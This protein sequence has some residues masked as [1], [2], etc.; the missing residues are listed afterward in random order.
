MFKCSFLFFFLQ[1]ESQ[2]SIQPSISTKVAPIKELFPHIPSFV[3]KT[4]ESTKRPASPY[5]TTESTKQPASPYCSTEYS[6]DDLT[7][8][9]HCPEP[10]TT[11]YNLLTLSHKTRLTENECDTIFSVPQV[12][13]EDHHMCQGSTERLV[14][15]EFSPSQS[16]A[17]H[18]IKPNLP[19][20]P[21]AD[22]GIKPDL[23]EVPKVDHGIKPDLPEVPKADHGIKPD[24]TEVP[25]VE[26]V[27]KLDTPES[28]KVSA[29]VNISAISNETKESNKQENE[30]LAQSIE[31]SSHAVN[32]QQANNAEVVSADTSVRD[33]VNKKIDELCNLMGVNTSS[34]KF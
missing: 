30:T 21:K 34:S 14:E 2:T 31:L 22:H 10:S 3:K 5:C 7:S 17:D 15:F 28:L 6:N 12:P 19:E 20:E 16:K 11:P 13:G 32:K 4:E 29:Q 33:E 27:A 1:N 23:P 25:K 9:L 24:L 26:Q 8:T 18:G